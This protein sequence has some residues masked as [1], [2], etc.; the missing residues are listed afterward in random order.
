MIPLF[1]CRHCR[2]H[3]LYQIEERIWWTGLF[4]AFGLAATIVY[5]LIWKLLA[6]LISQVAG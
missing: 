1:H 6:M 5:V 3:F 2:R 4:L